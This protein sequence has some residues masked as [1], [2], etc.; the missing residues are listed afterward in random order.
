[1]LGVELVADFSV[2]RLNCP[3]RLGKNLLA[4]RNPQSWNHGLF[5]AAARLLI[6]P[7]SVEGDPFPSAVLTAEV[8]RRVQRNEDAAGGEGVR[9]P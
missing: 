6:E 3:S 9:Q 1:M 2:V 5:M 8:A 4:H 7:S